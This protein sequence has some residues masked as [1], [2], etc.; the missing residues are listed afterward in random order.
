MK[1]NLERLGA[2]AEI[3]LRLYEPVVGA[4]RSAAGAETAQ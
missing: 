1:T 4:D 2:T 3:G